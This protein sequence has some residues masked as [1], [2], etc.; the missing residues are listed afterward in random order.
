MSWGEVFSQGEE[1]ENGR[2]QGFAARNVQN[3]IPSHS[4]LAIQMFL[5]TP[6]QCIPNSGLLIPTRQALHEERVCALF[7]LI[8][9]LATKSSLHFPILGAYVWIPIQ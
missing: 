8:Y 3:N 1:R 2:K 5:E 6:N 9:S 7:N 4:C